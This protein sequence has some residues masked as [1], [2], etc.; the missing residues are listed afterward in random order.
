MG[1]FD[2]L[3]QD[4]SNSSTLAMELSN[5]ALSH[6]FDHHAYRFCCKILDV[7]LKNN[8][9]EK[10]DILHNQI[11]LSVNSEWDRTPNILGYDYLINH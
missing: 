5:L 9:Y 8:D 3:M 1:Y 11:P 7:Y 2:G 6:R 10:S 4:C